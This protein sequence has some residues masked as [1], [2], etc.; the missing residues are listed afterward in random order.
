LDDG[1]QGHRRAGLIVLI[2]LCVAA[3]EGYDIQAFG[4]AAP[5]LAAELHLGPGQMGWA[6]GAAMMGLVVGALFGGW[7]ADRVGRKPVLV[8]SVA[9]FG[10]FSLATAQAH[11]YEPLLL[12]RFATGLGFGGAMPNLIAVATEI[13]APGRRAATV[14]TM[15]CGMPAGGAAVALLARYMGADLHWRDVF[16][17]GGALPVLL[18]PFV[19]FLLP[20]T[21]PEQQAGADRDLLR[22]LFGQG[23]AAGTLLLW[24]A[25]ILTLVVT[26]LMLNWLPTLVIAKG[27][28]PAVGSEASLAFNLTSIA[29]SLLLGFAVDRAG[30]RWPL[31]GAFAALAVAMF[32]LAAA[33]GATPVL[34]LSA[35][36]GFM[37]LGAQFVLY[38]I[39][40]TLYPPQ[41]RAAG[42]GAAVGVG[43][44]GSIAGPM[45][46]G[47]LREAG[48]GAGQV[49]GAMTPVVLAAGAAALALSYLSRP[50]DAS[51]QSAQ[52][53]RS[54][55]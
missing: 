5:K 47:Q 17:V 23:R 41:M 22:A 53:S 7:I 42:A 30:F 34:L 20:E 43:R 28:S 40:P 19:V 49:F 37:V 35:V 1:V 6:G 32:A 29:G 16:L 26:Y 45:I 39:A 14:T 36:A 15:F 50:H 52:R 38:A 10:L 9:A 33:T 48:H 11:G 8:A 2:C 12:A 13:S 54:P 4:V 27:L 44:L 51:S 3:L 46:A 55:G 25:F 18:T 21:R 31:T 24:V